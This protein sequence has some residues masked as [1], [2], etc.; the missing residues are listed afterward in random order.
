SLKSYWLPRFKEG[1]VTVVAAPIWISSTFV[2]EGALR[3]AVQVV[4]GLLSEIE[5]CS[6]DVALVTTYQQIEANKAAGKVSI[7]L[8]FEGAEPLGHDLGALRLFHAV[9]LRLLSLTWSRRNA[10]GDGAWEN[11]SRGGLSRLG[12][13]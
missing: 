13:Q 8:A 11:E 2:P 4:D 10:F 3:R 6:N 5:A 12:R 9:G 1:G 7:L